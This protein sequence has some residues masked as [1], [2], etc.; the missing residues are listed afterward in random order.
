MSTSSNT[1]TPTYLEATDPDRQVT[2]FAS[3]TMAASDYFPVW[4]DCMAEDVTLEGALMNGCYG[5]ANAGRVNGG[6]TRS[7]NT[8][9][10]C[11]TARTSALTCRS[12]RGNTLFWER[13][14]QEVAHGAYRDVFTAFPEQCISP[15]GAAAGCSRGHALTPPASM[16]RSPRLLSARPA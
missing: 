2:D 4:L 6:Q 9:G 8:S 7:V 5:N 13:A 14:R 3:N 10:T 15:H 11:E 1:G 12:V 16:L